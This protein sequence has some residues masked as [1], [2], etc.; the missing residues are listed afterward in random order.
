VVDEL[1]D[2]TPVDAD[3]LEDSV[4]VEQAVVED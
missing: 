1:E 2:T 3:A 4:A